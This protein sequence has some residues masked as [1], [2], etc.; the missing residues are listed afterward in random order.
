[1]ITTENPI[2]DSVITT[3]N[4]IYDSVLGNA[5]DTIIDNSNRTYCDLIK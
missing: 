2:Y 4:P 5:F 1:M 3:E